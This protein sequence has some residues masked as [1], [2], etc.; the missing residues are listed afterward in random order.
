MSLEYIAIGYCKMELQRMALEDSRKRSRAQS[1]G[2]QGVSMIEIRHAPHAVGRPFSE[3]V[4]P[5]LEKV[6]G[7]L[8]GCVS[9]YFDNVWSSGYM[10]QQTNDT[11]KIIENNRSQQFPR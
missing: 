3:R 1:A 4:W 10:D 8:K 5:F 11:R 7:V 6:R 9:F 2:E